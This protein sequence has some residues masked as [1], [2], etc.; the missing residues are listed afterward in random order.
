VLPVIST[1]TRLDG[2][3]QGASLKKCFDGSVYTT[4]GDYLVGTIMVPLNIKAST[5][6]VNNSNV[7]VTTIDQARFINK[8]GQLDE[9]LE[10]YSGT[11]YSDISE[12]ADDV[13]STLW[14]K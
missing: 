10:Y 12:S 11:A 13:T 4:N 9:G 7:T 1:P 8:D 14:I 2:T 3:V 5:L 6:S